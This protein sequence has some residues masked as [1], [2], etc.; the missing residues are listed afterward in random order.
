MLCCAV[1]RWTTYT[2]SA[3][4]IARPLRCCIRKTDGH[5]FHIQLHHQCLYKVYY[6]VLQFNNRFTHA[7][8]L[9]LLCSGKNLDQPSLALLHGP[10]AR[11]SRFPNTLQQ[12]RLQ[13][14]SGVG[15][16]SNHH[17]P[18]PLGG[19]V[20]SSSTMPHP[21]SGLPAHQF[22][23]SHLQLPRPFVRSS[24]RLPIPPPTT[25]RYPRSITRPPA[26]PTPPPRPIPRRAALSLT[27]AHPS[28]PRSA[29]VT[30][31]HLVTS[32]PP[33][34]TAHYPTGVNLPRPPTQPTLPPPASTPAC[35]A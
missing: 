4:T 2:H 3:V 30:S 32:L 20:H 9:I 35:K 26:H 22:H 18:G 5:S 21:R 23:I 16:A 24:V 27:P 7:T 17:Q 29:P 19:H 28:Y 33:S 15:G 34:C 8:E 13:R 1:L 11:F 25:V 10:S 31:D 6:L 12:L 14:C